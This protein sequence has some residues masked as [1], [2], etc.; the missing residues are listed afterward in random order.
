MLAALEEMANGAHRH[1]AAGDVA[2]RPAG[3]RQAYFRTQE[4]LH[5]CL[6]PFDEKKIEKFIESC[7]HTC[8]S[9]PEISQ[10]HQAELEL[11]QGLAGR[12]RSQL[13]AKDLLLLTIITP[14]HRYEA[15]LPRRCL[16]SRGILSGFLALLRHL[17]LGFSL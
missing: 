9:N 14:V 13:L 7:C 3:S 1:E 2:S 15:Y 17:Q 12:D 8:K 4:W 6:Q 11:E 10:P 5:Y 16:V